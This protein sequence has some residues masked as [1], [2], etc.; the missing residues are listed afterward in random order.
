M[1]RK[2]RG[3]TGTVRR[4]INRGDLRNQITY[5]GVRNFLPQEKK[6][7]PD[8]VIHASLARMARH[9]EI[10]RENGSFFVKRGIDRQPVEIP[11]APQATAA[12]PSK[13]EVMVIGKLVHTSM[14]DGKLI[15]EVEVT[16]LDN[17]K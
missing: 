9:N 16:S 8:K 5:D 7:A 6:E 10:I 4:A 17:S 3:I 14:K 1:A 2:F 15:A 13:D 12:K 11:A